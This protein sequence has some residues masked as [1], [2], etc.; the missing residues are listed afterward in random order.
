MRHT[1]LPKE[2]KRETLEDLSCYDGW[3]YTVPWAIECDNEGRM[4]IGLNFSFSHTEQ[5]T[6]HLK[7]RRHGDFFV[8]KGC[9]IGDF[10]YS[11]S[12]RTCDEFSNPEI[13]SPVSLT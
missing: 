13:F 8:V 1:V 7:V 2:Y 9:S 5:G 12:R 3:K 10:R 11:N 6:A 4:Y